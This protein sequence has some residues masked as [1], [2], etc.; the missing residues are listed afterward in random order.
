M[1]RL[2]AVNPEQVTGKTKMLLDGVQATLGMTPNLIRTL[3][4]SPDVLEAYLSFNAALGG[5]LLSDR[6]RE[7]IALATA[8]ANGCGYCLTAH[9]AIGKAVGLSEN[10]VLDSRQGISPDS[11]IEA[12]L[13]FTHQVLE[14][15]G[16]V[17]DNEISRLRSVGYGDA[18]IAEI[19]ANIV[20]NIFTNYFNLV[21]GTE[22]DFPEVPTLVS[23]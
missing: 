10:D 17:S 6:L 16:R 20:L 12:A 22:I 2:Q 4:N 1:P 13:R 9:C 21:A 5:G 23:R 8:E 19:V 11:R 14:K 15:R 18:E 7:R 3:A